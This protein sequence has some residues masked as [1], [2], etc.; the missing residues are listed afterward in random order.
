MQRWMI[1]P[2][3][4]CADFHGAC[5]NT[6][7]GAG[8]I[9]ATQAWLQRRGQRYQCHP[10]V[11]LTEPLCIFFFSAGT[12]HKLL[13]RSTY[14]DSIPL[15]SNSIK[16]ARRHDLCELKRLD[17]RVRGYLNSASSRWSAMNRQHRPPMVESIKDTLQGAGAELGAAAQ[18]C[19]SCLNLIGGFS[20][21]YREEGGTADRGRQG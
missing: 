3:C 17:A 19:E 12:V 2:R 13:S 4:I 16:R 21:G 5:R 1:N 18:Q 9:L 8:S 10:G 14:I 6:P 11:R 20:W 7:S 15:R